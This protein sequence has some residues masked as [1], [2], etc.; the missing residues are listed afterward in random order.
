MIMYQVV[1][2]LP[3]GLS[4]AR[5]KKVAEAFRKAFGRLRGTVGLRFVPPAEIQRLN[6]AYR[7]KDCPTDVLSFAADAGG[8][9]WPP[10]AREPKDL[11][12]LVVCPSVAAKEATRRAMDPGEELVRLIAHGTLH[13]A[14][15]DHATAKDEERMFAIQEKIVERVMRDDARRSGSGSRPSR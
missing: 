3:R 10:S 1:G 14:G 12:D 8:F 11:G 7:A 5:L 15:M 6:R 4:S 13:L 9:P 2:R